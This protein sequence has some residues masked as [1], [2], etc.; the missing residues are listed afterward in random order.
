MRSSFRSFPLAVLAATCAGVLELAACSAPPAERVGTVEEAVKAPL[1]AAYCSVKVTG[2]GLKATEEDY[3][4]HVVACEN[5]G[6]SLEALKAQ[7]IAARSVAYYEMALYGDICDGQGC[8]VYTCSATPSALVKKAVLET[9]GVYLAYGGMLT[10][11]FY[12]DGDP[13]TALPSCIGSTTYKNEKWVTYNDG[14]SGKSVEQTQLGFIGPP[15]FGQNRGCM[16]QWGARCLEKTGAD[17]LGILRFYYGED[18]QLLQGVGPCVLLEDADGDGR[19]DS[20][21]NC[22][23][24]VNP[25]QTDTDGD[26]DGDACDLDDDADGIA[27]EKDNC[28]TVTNSAQVDTDGD[29]KGDACDG[30]APPGSDADGDG[31][32]DETDLC[33]QLA[34]AGNGDADEDGL[35][36]ACDPDADG[37]GLQNGVDDCPNVADPEQNLPN[38]EGAFGLT[39]KGSLQASASCSHASGRSGFSSARWLGLLAVLG[40]TRRRRSRSTIR[41]ARTRRSDLTRGR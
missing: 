17:Y 6:A 8:Q 25:A 14:L 9:S 33:P 26:G 30:D 11:P 19:S 15:G 38:C 10:Y 20:T 29:G 24:T 39:G 3:L 16:S 23:N 12:V 37:D 1:P 36:D 35:G 5:G 22:V 7:A 31:F 21:D 34:S 2:K 13:K 27:D 28:S 40:L 41:I 32:A 18:I 4:P